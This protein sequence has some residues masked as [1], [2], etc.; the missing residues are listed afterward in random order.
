M[1]ECGFC[2]ER[3]RERGGGEEEGNKIVGVV[4]RKPDPQEVS[5]IHSF[6]NLKKL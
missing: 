3:E 1:Y 6:D 4:E 5:R 2:G